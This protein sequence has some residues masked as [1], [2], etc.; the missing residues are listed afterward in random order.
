MRERRG[1]RE[2]WEERTINEGTK[3]RERRVGGED[4]K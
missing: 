4:N 3:R 2:E 1:G